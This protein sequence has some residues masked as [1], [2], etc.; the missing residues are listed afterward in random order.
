[1]RYEGISTDAIGNKI[2]TTGGKLWTRDRTRTEAITQT[3][4]K[5]F[6]LHRL[7]GKRHGNY[8]KYTDELV[9]N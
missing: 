1:M 6:N 4:H 2:F 9:W 8:F 5:L 7:L 3:E